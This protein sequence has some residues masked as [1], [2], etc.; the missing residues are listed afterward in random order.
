MTAVSVERD[1]RT[2]VVENA[3]YRWAYFVLSYGILA[4]VIYRGFVRHE[5]SWDLLGLVIAS[6]AVT[7]FYQGRQRVLSSHWVWMSLIAVAAAA[8]LAAILVWFR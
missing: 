3:S 8:V 7:T 6:G 2:L 1:E 4:A 5:A